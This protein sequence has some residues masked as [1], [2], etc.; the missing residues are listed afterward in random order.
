[1]KTTTPPTP[2]AVGDGVD[3]LGPDGTR[4]CSQCGVTAAVPAGRPLPRL[5]EPYRVGDYF[6]DVWCG[7]CVG[8]LLDDLLAAM[9]TAWGRGGAQS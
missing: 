2:P 9:R 3:R 1:M 6:G 5:W 4:T 8:K 7:D